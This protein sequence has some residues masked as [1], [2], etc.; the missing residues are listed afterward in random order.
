MKL[1]I[2]SVDFDEETITFRMVE[3]M[4]NRAYGCGA[5]E[6]DIDAI[7]QTLEDRAE[8]K[9]LLSTAEQTGNVYRAL[10]IAAR[11]VVECYDDHTCDSYHLALALSDLRSALQQQA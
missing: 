5:A 4:K 10:A 6:V 11:K 2:L 1:P 8:G 3:D 7:S 9:Q